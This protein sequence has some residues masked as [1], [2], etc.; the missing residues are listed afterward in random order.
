MEPVTMMMAASAVGSAV[1]G[2]GAAGA[3]GGLLAGGGLAGGLAAGATAPALAAAGGG[4]FSGITAMQ[5]LSFASTI[6]SGLMG[7]GQAN[8]QA[9]SLEESAMWSD[10][11]AR[12]EILKGKQEA[13]E[14]K[15]QLNKVIASNITAGY[16]SGLTGSGSVGQASIDAM[17]E[18]DYQLGIGRED[19]LMRAGTRRMQG[20]QQ[21]SQAST[22]RTSGLWSLV[23]GVGS[24]AM[25]YANRGGTT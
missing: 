6:A 3:A 15:R 23:D 16:A 19:A 4:L 14:Q 11:S 2:A 18:A 25:T 5:G 8:A 12:Q 22:T 10:F 17:E 13:V 24:A 9:S 20:R 7:M 1:G 21:R